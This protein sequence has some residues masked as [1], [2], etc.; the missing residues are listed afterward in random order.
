MENTIIFFTSDNGWFYGEHRLSSKHL[1][2]EEAIRVPLYVRMPGSNSGRTLNHLTLNN[3][4]APTIAAL[5]GAQPTRTVDGRSFAPLLLGEQPLTW[6]KQFLVEH[7]LGAWSGAANRVLDFANLFAVRTG[8]ES[9]I[10][11]RTYI[12]HYDGIQKNGGYFLN[13]TQRQPSGDYVWH[14][15]LLDTEYYDVASDPLQV[16]NLFYNLASNPDRQEIL[17]EIDELKTW[18]HQLLLCK[19]SG[20]RQLEDQ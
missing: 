12:E 11:D 6:R 3:D 17:T 5:A 1:A 16:R 2:Y 7:Y 18:L 9:A 10:P 14:G 20:C 4:L 13:E 19:G 8:T 15:T